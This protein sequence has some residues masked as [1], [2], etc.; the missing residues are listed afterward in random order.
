MCLVLSVFEIKLTKL[1]VTAGRI[2]I[3]DSIVSFCCKVV[4]FDT[5]FTIFET[6]FTIFETIFT[7]DASVTSATASTSSSIAKLSWTVSAADEFVTSGKTM[8]SFVPTDVE[9]APEILACG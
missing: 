3:V 2:H 5:I 8:L 9:E 6:I 7:F 1:L 4:S